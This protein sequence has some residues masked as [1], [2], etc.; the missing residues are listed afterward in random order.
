MAN[1]KVDWEEIAAAYRA[2]SL[3]IRA[4][5]E[6]HGISDTAIRLHAKKHG[7][8]RDLSSSVRQATRSK[9]ALATVK[10]AE[11]KT[12]DEIVS[13]A[14]DENALIVLD[15][16]VGLSKWRKIVNKYSDSLEKMKITEE[17]YEKFAR[18]MNTGLDAQLKVIKGERQA[19]SMDEESAVK[20]GRSLAEL[21][22]EV[23]DE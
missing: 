20:D 4:I 18:S 15:H 3:S 5:A 6:K 12:D 13:D 17:N 10:D 2:G 9:L 21:M 16:R 7:L 1:E 8:T 23:A 14:A 22:A 19:Y 11:G